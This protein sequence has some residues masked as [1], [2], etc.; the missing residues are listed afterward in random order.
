MLKTFSRDNCHY[1]ASATSDDKDGISIFL[2][3]YDPD[4]FSKKSQAEES[5]APSKRYHFG[6]DSKVPTSMYFVALIILTTV[7]FYSLFFG[8]GM[9]V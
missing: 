9:T 5:P 2:W 6:G 3:K 1:I 7:N 4:A 8:K